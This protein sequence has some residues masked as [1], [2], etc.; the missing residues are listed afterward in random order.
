M[1]TV[2]QMQR[3]WDSRQYSR[4]VDDLTAQRV[5]GLAVQ[6]LSARP[7][8]AAAAWGLIRLE[9]L[10]QPQAQLGRAWIAAILTR[11]ESDGGWGDV[12]VTA[13]CL[14]ALSLWQG[15]GEAIE[16]GMN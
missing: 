10:N 8:V 4:L 12:A 14:R 13:L 15:Q 6:E 16:R 2:R 11:Q 3:L 7:A 5:E 1:M 9:E